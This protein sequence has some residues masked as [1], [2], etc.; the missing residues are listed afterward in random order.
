MVDG[1]NPRV[2]CKSAGG[3]PGGVV[4]SSEERILECDT[5]TLWNCDGLT[6]RVQ[7]LLERGEHLKR[8]SLAFLPDINELPNL[9]L[10]DR[11]T[12]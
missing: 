7:L 10:Q 2:L 5:G 1:C 8:E 12:E 6:L 11:K 4:D 9:I 3:L